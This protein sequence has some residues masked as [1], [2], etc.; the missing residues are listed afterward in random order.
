MDV[1]AVLTRRIDPSALGDLPRYDEALYLREACLLTDWYLP[2][3]RR[4][5]VG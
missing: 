5:G 2:A 1:L 4:A 3:T